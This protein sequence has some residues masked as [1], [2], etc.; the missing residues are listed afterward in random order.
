MLKIKLLYLLIFICQL[1]LSQT[2]QQT[3]RGTILD[4]ETYRPISNAQLAIASI[5]DNIT[6]DIAGKYRIDA[7]PIG[8]HQLQVSAEGYKTLNVPILVET[9]R[10]LILEIVLHPSTSAID[11]IM[12]KATRLEATSPLSTHSITIEETLRLPA[13]FYDPA[14]MMA[15]HAGVIAMND[16][17]NHISVRGNS[18]N[19]L[20]WRLEGLEI[21]NPNHTANAGT[22]TDLP[23]FNGGGVNML[24][25][26]MLGDSRFYKGN[27]PTQDGNVIGGML[28]MR[29]RKGND[30]RHEFIGQIGLIGIDVAAE[31]PISKKSRAS[32]LANYRYSTL[33]L[34][35]NLGV[36]L[37]DEAINFQ[38]AAVHLSLPTQNQGNF[39]LFGI[40][41][42][43]SNVF[44][45]QRDSSLWTEQ[46]A[47][48]DINFQSNM[49]IVGGTHGIAVG[50]QGYWKTSVAHSQADNTRSIR[51]FVG[52]GNINE[53]KQQK[54]ALRTEYSTRF[55]A[56][57]RLKLGASYT[58]YSWIMGQA[59]QAQNYEPGI[60]SAYANWTHQFNSKLKAD[61]GMHTLV[62]NK[63]FLNGSLTN[64]NVSTQIQPRFSLNYQMTTKQ[65]LH[66]AY[67]HHSQLFPYGRL[68]SEQL[69]LNYKHRFTPSTNLQVEWYWQNISP[70]INQLDGSNTIN[71][72]ELI[73]FPE[74]S[75]TD[76]KARNY[77]IEASLQ[78]YITNDYYFIANATL[79]E[80]EFQD[81][82]GDWQATR[83]NNNY[84]FNL[85]GG[86][87]W[88]K[89]KK[90][91]K[92]IFGLNARLAYGGGARSNTI[93]IM[94]S[95]A[96]FT[97]YTDVNDF[98]RQFP[99]YFK[100][101]M[102]LYWKRNKAKHNSMFALDIQNAT[103]AQNIA[104]E[105]YDVVQE[106][107]VTKYQLG[108]IPIL[109]WRIE[110]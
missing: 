20:S 71:T 92:R 46:K 7:I 23:T 108:I 96:F 80:S 72:F 110:L 31:G 29:L 69:G 50:Q 2:V 8:R 18:P 21:V 99:D 107:I 1:G 52:I 97:R 12:V 35:S 82:N 78:R 27:F 70:S 77:G 64:P 9:G 34:L 39:T 37:G 48:F 65:S 57:N 30:E 45:G 94:A 58:Q 101:D 66:L 6:T 42:K 81:D 17:A 53:L 87:E 109:S 5:V 105:Y 60:T 106:K 28:D 26:Q 68:E 24:S 44:E 14:R 15:N 59:E 86:K 4:V 93:D 62:T 100:L 54:T 90:K 103:N 104:F 19:H 85:T 83:W 33:G 61:A 49:L 95:D 74:A 55:D 25:A 47:M 91:A 41:G 16:Q 43:S 88:T 32:Y 102:R 3:L 89:Q 51:D 10:E 67:G 75:P 11:T 73:A 22:I 13:T 56:K 84:A 40:W 76:S 98:S 36:D 63:D 38:D 79:F